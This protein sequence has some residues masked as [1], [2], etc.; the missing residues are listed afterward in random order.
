MSV[1]SY[2]FHF[3]LFKLP[4]KGMSFL[5]PSLKLPNKE[6]EEYFKMILFIPFHSL[7]P[8]TPPLFVEVGAQGD[9]VWTLNHSLQQLSLFIF[10]PCVDWISVHII[11]IQKRKMKNQIR[12]LKCRLEG[13]SMGTL[14][15]GQSANW[16]CNP[17]LSNF[18]YFLFCSKFQ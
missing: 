11:K 4:N 5:F 14:I 6:R 2:S 18:Y 16:Q 15:S 3:L 9:V 1:P 12:A 17:G 8:R 13:V 7:L 10:I